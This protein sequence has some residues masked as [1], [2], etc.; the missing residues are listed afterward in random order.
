MVVTISHESNLQMITIYYLFNKD[1]LTFDPFPVTFKAVEPLRDK[2]LPV[3]A[4]VIALT[5]YD[6]W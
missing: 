2:L 5:V 3:I 4:Y 6:S 1:T